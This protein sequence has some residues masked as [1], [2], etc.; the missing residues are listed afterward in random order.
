[1][2]YIIPNYG[3]IT[4]M[5]SSVGL[6]Y[7]ILSFIR[8]R[9]VCFVAIMA[10]IFMSWVCADYP[11]IGIDDANIFFGYAENIVNGKGITY[12]NNGIPVEGCTSLAWL[13]ICTIN[14]LIGFDEVGVFLCSCVALM[15]GQMLWIEILDRLLDDSKMA[16]YKKVS[17]A[18]YCG[19]LLSCP[20]Y[21]TWM[22]I[23]LMDT[24]LWGAVIALISYVLIEELNGKSQLNPFLESL[25]F[26]VAVFVRPESLYAVAVS[27][28][29]ILASRLIN[30]SSLRPIIVMG[31]FFF[32]SVMVLTLFRLWYFGHP[33]PNTYYAKVSSSLIYN[34][35][36]GM[37]YAS[38]YIVSGFP[39]MAFALC[40]VFCVMGIPRLFKTAIVERS[41]NG[42]VPLIFWC[43]VLLLMMMPILTGGDHF[44][45]HRFFQPFYPPICL[46]LVWGTIKLGL[47]DII[48]EKAKLSSRK[49]VVTVLISVVIVFGWSGRFSWA[50]SIMEGSVLSP[51]FTIA[52]E[53]YRLGAAL[54]DFFGN[55]VD[56]P[57]VG[58]V[59]AGGIARSYSGRIIDLM[60]LNDVRV[61]HYPGEKTWY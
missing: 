16:K 15:I 26:V 19:L 42:M 55:S 51:E 52:E 29:I 7:K 37:V 2:A 21:I 43:W 46:L 60:G 6:S 14:F 39:T 54:N 13:L 18:L 12:S 47:I 44:E 38:Q 33:F 5:S 48:L 41:L 3:I 24:V 35:K 58:S 1:M 61:A 25:P 23:T 36:C 45:F 53:D 20:A 30:R 34:L 22:S 9:F 31:L 57:A 32:I 10:A 28:S 11:S 8:E 49:V 50:F 59:T 56:L 27:L 40:S 4:P 17:F